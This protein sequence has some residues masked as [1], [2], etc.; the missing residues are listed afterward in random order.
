M[1]RASGV[2]QGIGLEF[3]PQH[4][5]NKKRPPENSEI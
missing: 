5:N 2:A 3:K 4:C 1:K